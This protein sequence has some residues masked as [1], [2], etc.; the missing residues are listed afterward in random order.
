MDT[1]DLQKRLDM[2]QAVAIS[3][4]MVVTA[5]DVEHVV[6]VRYRATTGE[7]TYAKGI[8]CSLTSALVVAVGTAQAARQRSK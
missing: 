1:N 5:D 3:S 6:T 8:A 4:E 2:I 7:L